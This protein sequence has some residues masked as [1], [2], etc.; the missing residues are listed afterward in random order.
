MLE[1]GTS[2]GRSLLLAGQPVL[3]GQCRFLLF[4]EPWL[5][6]LAAK[7]PDGYFIVWL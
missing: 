6:A 3:S 5:E 2:G 7:S 4:S 1:Q